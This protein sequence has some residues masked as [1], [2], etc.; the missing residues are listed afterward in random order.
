MGIKIFFLEN[1][2]EMRYIIENQRENGH[3]I[4]HAK[5]LQNA[6]ALLEMNPGVDY[7]DLFIFDLGLR[8]EKVRHIGKKGKVTYDHPKELNGLLFLLN[9]LDILGDKT[10]EIALVSAYRRQITEVNEVTIDGKNFKRVPSKAQQ[11]EDSEKLERVCYIEE[12]SGKKYDIT[13]L[14]KGDNDI[15]LLIKKF[16]HRR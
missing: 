15:A 3:Q 16:I 8:A 7:F 2:E 10:K 6:A 9:N 4:Y 1:D 11:S 12:S 13:F 14:D 5:N